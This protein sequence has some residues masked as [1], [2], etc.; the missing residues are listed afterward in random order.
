MYGNS[1]NTNHLK[2][3]GIIFLI[4]VKKIIDEYEQTSR[5]VGKGFFSNDYRINKNISDFNMR[6]RENW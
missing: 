4:Y 5:K 6:E 2:T 1:K 3:V